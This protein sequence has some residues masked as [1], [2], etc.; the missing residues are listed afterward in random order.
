MKNITKSLCIFLSILCIF[1]AF[2]SC[3]TENSNYDPSNKN[4]NPSENTTAEKPQAKK[5]TVVFD[6]NNGSGKKE[7]VYIPE[8]EYITE[9]APYPIIGNKEVVAWSGTKDGVKYEAPISENITL[10]AQWQSYEKAIYTSDFPNQINDRIVEIQINGNSDILS[11]KVLRIGANVQELTIISDGTTYNNFAIIINQR[12]NDIKLTLDSFCYSSNQEFALKATASAV[13]YN[14]N[15]TIKNISSI[16]CL[17]YVPSL[18]N[19]GANCII[20]PNLSITG[21]GT[22]SLLAGS[23]CNGTNAADAENGKDGTAGSS[24]T[25]GGV[26][27]IADSITVNN[28]NLK[29]VGGNGGKGGNGGSGNNG[30]GLFNSD[31][32]KD[33]GNGG[34][35]GAGG[36]AINTDYFDAT[37]A[38]LELIGGVGGSGGNGGRS[39]G[40][41]SAYAGHG[42]NGGNGGNGG[43]VFSKNMSTYY[44]SGCVNK[45]TPGNGGNAGA[46]G[47]SSN[48]AKIGNGGSTGLAGKVNAE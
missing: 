41:S 32:F 46:G 37:N 6:Y 43:S 30:N 11:G 10:Y 22:L 7:T 26:G 1:L 23:G 12:S 33:G 20:A 8:G 3:D 25:N 47:D 24:A 27:I 45:Y 44:E 2:S 29:V 18:E 42:G 28:I 17:G 31:K 36:D 48:N 35:G 38:T 14:V 9:Y 39:G 16:D 4:D 19:N 21:N 13:K 5:Y 34:N 40:S 15:L